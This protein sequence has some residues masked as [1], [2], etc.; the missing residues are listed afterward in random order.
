MWGRGGSRCWVWLGPQV[1]LL[2]DQGTVMP[3]GFAVAE[4]LA[5]VQDD[6]AS[7]VDLVLHVGDLSYA[8][9]DSAVPALNISKVRCAAAAAAALLNLKSSG[10]VSRGGGGLPL[11]CGRV[12]FFVRCGATPT[13][14]CI[15]CVC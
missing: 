12:N 4:K 6:G 7:L 13:F 2:A 15:L 14:Q 10:R 3:L 9:V 8:G 1:A 5:A 11:P